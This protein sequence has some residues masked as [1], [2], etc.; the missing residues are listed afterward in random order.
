[1][2]YIY[3]GFKGTCR[4]EKFCLFDEDSHEVEFFKN[5]EELVEYIIDNYSSEFNNLCNEVENWI[6]QL[7][8]KNSFEISRKLSSEELCFLVDR[9]KTLIY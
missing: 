6:S 2:L 4:K 3:K 9:G 8:K 7:L 5:E 1:M